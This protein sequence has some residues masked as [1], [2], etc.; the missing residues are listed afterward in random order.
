MFWKGTEAFLE[1]RILQVNILVW[2]RYLADWLGVWSLVGPN[3]PG[4]LYCAEIKFW[5][6][7]T[8]L[9]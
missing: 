2:G 3:T 1:S 8:K 6:F 7:L 9:L 5:G 4:D